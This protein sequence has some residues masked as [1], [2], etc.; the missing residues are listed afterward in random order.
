MRQTS[1]P[2]Y[3]P[4]S[5]AS[6][7]AKPRSFARRIISPVVLLSAMIVC[8]MMSALIVAATGG[9]VA[10]Q[11]ERNIRATQTATADIDVQFGLGV[12]DLEQGR[13]KL[14]AQRFRWIL[15]RVPDYPNA[16]DKL[17]EAERLI[18]EADGLETTLPPSDAESPDELFTEAKDYY[19]RQ[20]WANAITR[21]Q[22]LQTLDP[23]YRETEVKN[24]LHEALKTLG[25]SYVRGDKLEEGLFLLEQAEEIRPLD[26]QAA[27][28]RYLADLYIAGLSYWNLSWA[29]VIENFQIIYD[30]VPNY[31]D[32][33]DRLWEARVKYGDQLA[34][35]GA[36]CEAADQ[37]HSALD[38]RG[39]SSIREKY[40]AASDACAN[41][42]PIPTATPVVS[43]E[44]TPTDTPEGGTP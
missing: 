20:Q 29:V 27:G 33:A 39:D 30:L 14:A 35:Q 11:K 6:A 17:A 37:Y 18:N 13:Y 32:V 7:P 10:G 21:L 25:L 5:G 43:D 40:Y 38:M 36:Q 12:Q 23:R 26:D 22:E 8:V 19:D 15:E 28:E 3:T 4:A 42:T 34:G 41:P 16:A 2:I 1:E 24:M 44:P 31:R 9:A